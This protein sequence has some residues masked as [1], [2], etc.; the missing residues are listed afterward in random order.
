MFEEMATSAG[1]LLIVI[2]SI[3]L[4]FIVLYGALWMRAAKKAKAQ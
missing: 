4:L 3:T 1:Q 2:F